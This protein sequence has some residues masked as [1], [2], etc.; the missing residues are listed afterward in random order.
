MH[1]P[2]SVARFRLQFACLGGMTCRW[3]TWLARFPER[4]PMLLI[5]R[6]IT[7]HPLSPVA[8]RTHKS[9]YRQG[10]QL[11]QSNSTFES[12]LIRCLQRAFQVTDPDPRLQ[13]KNPQIAALLTFIIPGAGQLYQG[14]TFKGAVFLICILGTFL[15]GMQKSG[16][17]A[18]YAAEVEE[19]EHGF[20]NV[21]RSARWPL[22]YFA[23]A[24]MG[25]PAT[26][27]LIQRQ[28]FLSADNPVMADSIDGPTEFEFEG[29]ITS[30]R[31]SV[32]V[33]GTLKLE[34]YMQGGAQ[35]VRGV[36]S[37]TDKEG[38]EL[39]F[40]VE[41]IPS[42]RF[43]ASPMGA[44]ARRHI[45]VGILNPER[46]QAIGVL[47][48][49][50]AR[51]LMNWLLMPPDNIALGELHGGL[52]KT[53]ELAVVCTWIAGLLNILAIWDAL[54]G[55][56]YGYGDEQDEES[57][58]KSDDAKD[59]AKSTADDAQPTPATA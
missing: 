7:H 24:G 40:P 41:P 33:S 47:R 21:R 10:F 22:G 51:P 46:D 26:F 2:P 14:R 16:W 53:F 29:Q 39:N 49:T 3:H 56:A 18:V 36:F 9:P 59:D 15:F 55:P 17:R 50:T 23:Q 45:N 42:E 20:N 48:G 12:H 11:E 35:N 57:D 25:L 13:L 52:G 34:S 37:G 44:S 8:I 58:G 30:G 28:R 54:E 6:R 27:A 5:H 38:L 4:S 1:W 43:M 19:T 31:E 32:D